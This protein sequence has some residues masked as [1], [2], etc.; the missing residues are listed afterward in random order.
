MEVLRLVVSG[1]SCQQIAAILGISVNTV[2]VHRAKL[3]KEI[4]AH[5]TADLVV[6]A[7]RNSLVSIGATQGPGIDG[8]FKASPTQSASM[9]RVRMVREF[10]PSAKT[11]SRE[12]LFVMKREGV[13]EMEQSGRLP[14]SR[15]NNRPLIRTL[16]QIS[17]DKRVSPEVR[18]RCC[19]LLL[20]IDPNIT[21][22]GF[23]KCNLQDSM[24]EEPAMPSELT[25]K[26]SPSGML[27]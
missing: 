22:N 26:D 13:A 9:P 1:K 7:I 14:M 2:E 10:T 12:E 11:P 27:R 19:E 17:R 15:Y 6:H 21:F 16:R 25:R 8:R 18:V 5:N 4:G 3:M 24:A 23:S 20:L